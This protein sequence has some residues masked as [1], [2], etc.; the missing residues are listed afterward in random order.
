MSAPL[1][2]DWFVIAALGLVIVQLIPLPPEVWGRL[3]GR[4]LAMAIDQRV[5]G[6]AH[7]RPLSLDPS[8]TLRTVLAMLPGLATYCAVRTGGSLRLR[9]IVA[10]FAV[11]AAVSLSFGMM[12]LLAPDLPEFR[13][14]GASEAHWPVGLF[15]NHNHQGMFLL[16]VLPLATGILPGPRS[17]LARSGTAVYGTAA[18]LLSVMVLATGSRSSAALTKALP[19]PLTRR[20]LGIGGAWALLVPVLIL[21]GGEVLTVTGNAG[22]AAQL[23]VA[24][25]SA[26]ASKGALVTASALSA[27]DISMLRAKTT[28]A[29]GQ[30]MHAPIK[31]TRTL[32]R[33]AVPK[34]VARSS[35]LAS[36]RAAMHCEAAR[37]RPR[38]NT[39]K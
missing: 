18:L 5:F 12:Q 4:G 39:P 35:A 15:A 3:P 19:H 27:G 11:A 38:S 17:R 7:W 32:Q 1:P 21:G 13:P 6:V 33:S 8:A 26:S 10:G 28:L 14:F 36:R 24:T 34:A 2:G 25:G 30:M 29:M 23:I 9:A 16:C 31:P 22:L 37:P 20:W